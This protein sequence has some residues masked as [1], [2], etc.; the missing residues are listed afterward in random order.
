MRVAFHFDSGSYGGF[1]G[2]P[3]TRLVFERLLDCVSCDRRDVFI[4]RGGMAIWD[5]GQSAEDLSS[6][7]GRMF[8]CSREIWSTLT[9][10]AFV[11]ALHSVSIWVLAVEGLSP[12]D[13]I[14]V[15]SGLDRATD[16]WVRLRS[17]WPTPR[18][19]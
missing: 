19:G 1:Y 7:A 16:T 14:C 8:E 15:D 17:T 10:D 18:T 3:I 12:A 5:L 4:R 6:L 13:A 9:E 11:K 2:P